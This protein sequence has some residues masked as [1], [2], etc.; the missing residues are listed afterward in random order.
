MKL[1]FDYSMI[2]MKLERSKL[3]CQLLDFNEARKIY[4]LYV[5]RIDVYMYNMY[6]L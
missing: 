6:T 5:N 2:L 3:V 4:K 1:Y